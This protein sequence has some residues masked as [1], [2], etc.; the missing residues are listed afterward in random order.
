[1]D[2]DSDGN[3]DFLLVGAPLFYRPQEKTEGKIYVYKLSDEVRNTFQL[4]YGFT[5]DVSLGSSKMYTLS[6]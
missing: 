3:T 5:V 1:M 2:L 6:S 4:N